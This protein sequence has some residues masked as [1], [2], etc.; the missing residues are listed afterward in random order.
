MAGCR[1]P[2]G[3]ARLDRRYIETHIGLMNSPD[4]DD[5][6]RRRHRHGEG[7]AGRH[8]G[9]VFDYGELRLVVLAMIADRPR[10]GYDLIKAIGERMAGSYTPSPGVIY[11]TLAWLEEMGYAAVQIEAGGRKRYRITGAGM[12]FVAANRQAA[13][14]VFARIGSAGAGGAGPVPAPVVRGMEN[15]KLALRLRLKRDPIDRV[16]AERIAAALDSAAREIE[17]S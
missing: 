7:F 17:R 13:D 14:A 15:L 16:A 2:A 6:D 10:H 9:R 11:P 5:P 8:G 4:A 1:V 12:A 3:A